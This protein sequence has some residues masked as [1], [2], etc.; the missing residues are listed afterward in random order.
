MRG[1]HPV[2][3]ARDG[4]DRMRVIVTGGA[5]RLGR[6]VVEV[7]SAAGHAVV[8]LDR[9]VGGFPPVVEQH[10]IDLTDEAATRSLFQTLRPDAV[11]HLAGIAVPFSAPES[12]IWRTNTALVMSVLA[13]AVEAGA[14]RV[15]AASSPTVLGYGSPSGWLPER[16]PLDETSR[17]APWNAYSLSKLAIE[18]TAAMFAR[19]HPAVVFGSFR[20]CFV[21]SPEEWAGAP[22]QQGHTVEQRLADPSLAAVSLFNYVDARD[23]ASFVARWTAAATADISGEV[24]F[25]GAD[26]ALCRGDVREAIAAAL[27]GASGPAAGL[28]PD[29]AAFSSAKALRLLGWRPRYSW[30]TELLHD[31]IDPEELFRS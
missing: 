16:L 12:V 8:S 26:D 6:S 15:L 20:P 11:V 2:R 14:G 27:P 10:A 31:S 1:T 4:P 21:L 25:V 24:F 17:T 3:E 29:Q 5:G 22:T 28:R 30:R 9:Q 19:A 18:E 7:L 13:A 23:A